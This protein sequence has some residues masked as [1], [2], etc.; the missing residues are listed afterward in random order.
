MTTRILCQSYRHAAAQMGVWQARGC[1]TSIPRFDG[2]DWYLT[3]M[4]WTEYREA[5]SDRTT[6]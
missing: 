3:Y 1:V 5:N 2:R 6:G 4:T